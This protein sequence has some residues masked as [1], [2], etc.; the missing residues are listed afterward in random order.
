MFRNFEYWCDRDNPA[1]VF[2]LDR[3]AIPVQYNNG[4]IW[5][6]SIGHKWNLFIIVSDVCPYFR[7]FCKL[8]FPFPCFIFFIQSAQAAQNGAAHRE[9]FR[10]TLW[11]VRLCINY[12]F[13]TTV[14]SWWILKISSTFLAVLESHGNVSIAIYHKVCIPGCA[15]HN[16]GLFTWPWLYHRTYNRTR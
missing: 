6:L 14:Y 4:K 13:L 2:T 16:W 11:P 5:D 15:S 7:T 1:L 3:C 8:S 9:I 12:R 10:A